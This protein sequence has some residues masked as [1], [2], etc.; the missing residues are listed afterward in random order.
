MRSLIHGAF[1]SLLVVLF[2]GCYEVHQGRYVAEKVPE[3]SRDDAFGSVF[4]RYPTKNTPDWF[5]QIGGTNVGTLHL[6]IGS[7]A[8]DPAKIWKLKMLSFSGK[9]IEVASHDKKG[10]VMIRLIG[11]QTPL[12]QDLNVDGSQDFTVIVPLQ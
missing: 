11:L 1:A 8:Y 7:D 4:F 3:W 9:P 6:R 10:E 5:I 2:A 12:G